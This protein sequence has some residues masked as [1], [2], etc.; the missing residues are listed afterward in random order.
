MHAHISEF[1][2]LKTNFKTY[3]TFRERGI[4]WLNGMLVLHSNSRNIVLHQG[5][6][7]DDSKRVVLDLLVELDGSEGHCIS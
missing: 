5:T 3:W 4:L 1:S 6:I 2:D 7:L